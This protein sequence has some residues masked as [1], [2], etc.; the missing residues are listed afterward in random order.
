MNR[1]SLRAFEPM[2]GLLR[3]QEALDRAFEGPMSQWWGRGTSA[4]GVFPAVNVWSEPDGYVL[5][6]EVPGLSPEELSIETHGRTL[7]VSGKRDN[8][9]EGSAHR[10]ER[11]SGEFSRAFE[12]PQ[13]LEVSG[14]KAEYRHGVLTIRVPRREEAKPRQIEVQSV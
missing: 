10:V 7:R 2:G 5:T 13:D 4:R 1:T 9:E 3:L 11:W 8:G 6:M 12:L 14:A